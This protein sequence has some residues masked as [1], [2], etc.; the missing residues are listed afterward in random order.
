MSSRPATPE[1][2]LTAAAEQLE[3][4]LRR[5]ESL[6]DSLEKAPL[7]T[8]KQLERAAGLVQEVATLDEKLGIHVQALATAIGHARERQHAQS[9]RVHAVAQSLEQRTQVFQ[10]LLEKY[11][12]LGRAAGELNQFASTVAFKQKDGAA[13]SEGAELVA[14]MQALIQRMGDVTAHA[15]SLVQ[16][17][18]QAEF[19]DMAR[20]ADALRQQLLAARNKMN[21]LSQKMASA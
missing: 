16:A 7:N 11:A 3:A 10:G 19:T 4:D 2:E 20:Q 21:L 18:E 15:E 1:S 17:A 13:P 9:Q 5:F 8:E 6:T 12:A 14:G